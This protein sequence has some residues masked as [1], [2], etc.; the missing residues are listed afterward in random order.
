MRSKSY[1]DVMVEFVLHGVP[2]VEALEPISS[3]AMRK[4][5]RTLHAEEKPYAALDD[6]CKRTRGWTR[7]TRTPKTPKV[8]ETRRYSAALFRDRR[9]L[10]RVFLNT[11]G[12]PLE[13]DVTFGDKKIIL[14]PVQA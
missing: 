8:G 13:V 11:I 1:K 7:T 3:H 4:A 5:L 2:G 6:Y 10:A 9:V 12:E 14:V